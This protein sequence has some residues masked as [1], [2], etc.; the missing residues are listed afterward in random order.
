[1]ILQVGVKLI[2]ILGHKIQIRKI[3]LI[4]LKV[5]WVI[6]S[7]SI[8]KLIEMITLLYLGLRKWRLVSVTK[9]VYVLQNWNPQY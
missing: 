9:L 3:G 7:L 4:N 1:M 5:I 8:R 6:L 2:H